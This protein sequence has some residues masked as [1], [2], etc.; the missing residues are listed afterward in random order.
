MAGSK[1]E[2]QKQVIDPW[3]GIISPPKT[4]VGPWTNRF[5]MAVETCTGTTSLAANN[6]VEVQKLLDQAL[7]NHRRQHLAYPNWL[8]QKPCK[9]LV[10]PMCKIYTPLTQVCNCQI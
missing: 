6:P 9:H 8:D 5:G 1:A 3:E 2:V 10:S 7:T 4:K